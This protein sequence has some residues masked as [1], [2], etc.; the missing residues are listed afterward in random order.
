MTGRPDLTAGMDALIA[1][2]RRGFDLRLR[3]HSGGNLS[4]RLDTRD[5]IVIKPPGLGFAECSCEN[6]QVV[7]L[8]GTIL[9]SAPALKPR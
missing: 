9:P 3:A 1:A 7:R 5:A 2:A 8:N 4:V 6:L